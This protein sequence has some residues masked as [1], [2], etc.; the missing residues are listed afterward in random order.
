MREVQVGAIALVDFGWHDQA[1]QRLAIGDVVEHGQA[2]NGKRAGL[3]KKRVQ[4]SG[5]QKR[6]FWLP[7][8]RSE[9]QL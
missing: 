5:G 4:M 1:A 6:S 8:E 3:P 9:R 2:G 7:S